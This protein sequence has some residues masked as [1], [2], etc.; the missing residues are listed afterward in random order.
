MSEKLYAW[1]LRLYP[2]HFREDY[3]EEALRLFRDRARD[4]RGFF[5]RLRL[6]LDLFCDLAISVPREYFHV[7]SPRVAPLVPR[8]LYGFPAL[9][10]LEDASPRLGALLF[11]GMVSLVALTTCWASL[12][13]VR[14]PTA[15]SASQF[16]GVP[17]VPDG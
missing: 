10:V 4:E 11:G 13:S 12:T 16:A 15:S 2:A 14:G 9:F 17:D 6:W 3:G 8:R 5:P 1:L 7:P